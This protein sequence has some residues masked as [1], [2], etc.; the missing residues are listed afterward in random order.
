MIVL[1]LILFC[2]TCL[3][4]VVFLWFLFSFTM[5]K[6]CDFNHTTLC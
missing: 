1:V 3:I 5:S 2:V 6:L 4:S